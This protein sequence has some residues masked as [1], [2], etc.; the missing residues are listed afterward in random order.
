VKLNKSGKHFKFPDRFLTLLKQKEMQKWLNLTMNL[1]L[2]VSSQVSP[3]G[4]ENF[5]A[6]G[7]VISP[8]LFLR[9]KK[10]Y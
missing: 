10:R 9:P 5:R 2:K 7:R 3:Q 6:S 4:K 8:R 1:E